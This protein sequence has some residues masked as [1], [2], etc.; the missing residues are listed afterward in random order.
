LNHRETLSISQLTGPD[1]DVLAEAC[2]HLAPYDLVSETE[3]FVLEAQLW[4]SRLSER[5][6]R[7]LIVFRRFGHPSGGMLIRDIPIGAVPP[8]PEHADAAVGVTQSG[9]AAMSVLLA[10]LG[11]QYGFRPELGGNIIQDILP[12]F[13]FETEQISL[14]STVDLKDHTEMAFSRFRSDYVALLC[15]R[16]DHNR[17]AGTTLSAID[18]MLPLLDPEVIQLLSQPRFRT[19]VDPSFRIGDRLAEEIWIDPIRVFNGST[20]RPRLRV[21]FAETEGKDAAAQGALD[22][23][24]AA[25][26]EARCVVRLEAGDM[27]IVDND[28]AVHGRTPF[29][30]RYDGN[31]RW[32]L[33]SFV[34]RDL[35]RSES[36]RPADNR[37]VE[38]DYHAEEC[39]GLRS[40]A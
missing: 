24:A 14:G 11:D 16:Q 5:L 2:R 31:D 20:R 17:Q 1:Q 37:I 38:P 23:L 30:P 34:T 15:V 33:R 25:A 27:L 18:G 22:A 28:R 9:A 7:S 40:H 3:D 29:A 32:L 6:R 19:K 21:D 8:T 26:N 13:G 4:F 12:V 36:A 35:R 10:G 39:H